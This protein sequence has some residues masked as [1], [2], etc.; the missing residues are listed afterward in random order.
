MLQGAPCQTDQPHPPIP[1]QH[2]LNTRD[3]VTPQPERTTRRPRPQD[4]APSLHAQE[5]ASNHTENYPTDHDRATSPRP[6][7]ASWRWQDNCSHSPQSAPHKTSN[8]TEQLQSTCVARGMMGMFVPPPQELRGTVPCDC[9]FVCA[10]ALFRI[11]SHPTCSGTWTFCRTCTS[12]RSNCDMIFSL[13][14]SWALDKLVAFAAANKTST[15][16]RENMT[17]WTSFTPVTAILGTAASLAAMPSSS[18]RSK[19]AN[20]T[21]LAWV[22]STSSCSWALMFC[23]RKAAGAEALVVSA[24]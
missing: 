15:V 16:L 14:W 13:F 21:A 10:C 20:C 2:R 8:I 11:N 19:S 23:K 22:G 3:E 1:F 4:R 9:T 5:T 6:T 24:E 12:T 7:L 17:V 18:A